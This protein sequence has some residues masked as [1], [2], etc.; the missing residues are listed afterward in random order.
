MWPTLDSLA[1]QVASGLWPT[2]TATDAKASGSAG[3]AKTA[4]HNPGTTLTDATVRYPQWPVD[5]VWPTPRASDGEKGG[6]GQRGSSGDLMLPSAAVQWAT[7][8]MNE[9][10][11][12]GYL[13]G[14]GVRRPGLRRQA[15]SACLSGLL[16]P[17][18]STA[19]AE[20]LQSPHI[21]PRLSLNPLFVAWL[22]GW[23][24]LLAG[25]VES[26][27]SGCSATASSQLRPPLLSDS[28]GPLSLE[29]AE[30]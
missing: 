25:L 3:Y 20:S 10:K 16:A 22:M 28:S 21:S 11:A 30:P 7:P 8:V 19:G 6:P 27:S 29:G 9:D 4:T 18:T 13:S 23:R 12:S 5:A 26:T 17:L 24:W 2:A 15:T 14:D 1:P